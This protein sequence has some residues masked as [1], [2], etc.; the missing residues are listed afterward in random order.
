MLKKYN[1]TIFN[2]ANNHSYDMGSSGF[3]QSKENLRRDGLLFY[4]SQYSVDNGS[5]ITQKGGDYDIAFIGVND[6]NSPV[7]TW[8]VKELI[9]RAER[10]ADYTILNI[11]WGQEYKE[12]S[13]SRQRSLAR[14][15]IDAGVDAIIGHHP[16]VIQEME[17]YKDRPIFYSL[18]NFVF[19]QYFSTP[20]QRGLGV[21]LTFEDNSIS[22]KIFPFKGV[23]SQVVLL[24][25]T[26]KNSWKQGWLVKSRL[27]GYIFDN[28]NIRTDISR[29]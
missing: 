7:D 14:A 17:I 28:F 9:A 25:D 13:N 19:D 29:N 21:G 22:V 2:N 16:H 6:T 12:V 4:G 5:M 8:K 23:R 27:N 11:H 20:T 26:G 18:G 3:E 24:N 10:E 15:F 1:L